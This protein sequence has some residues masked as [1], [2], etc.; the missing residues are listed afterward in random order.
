MPNSMEVRGQIITDAIQTQYNIVRETLGVDDFHSTATLWN[1]GSI[2]F[3]K[4]YLK[5]PQNTIIVFC[6]FGIDQMLGEDFYM[7]VLE[8]GRKCGI[9]Y[10]I[11]YF[12]RGPHLT[13]GCHPEKMAYNYRNAAEYGKL[14][15]SILNVSNVRPFHFSVTMN[16]KLMENPLEVNMAAKMLEFDRKVYG[17]AGEEVNALRKEYYE[18][19]ADFREEPLKGKMERWSFY[20]RPYEDISFMRNAATDGQLIWYGKDVLSGNIFSDRPDFKED[21]QEMKESARRFEMLY[22][23]MDLLEQKLPQ[24]SIPYF[25]KFLKH[26]TQHMQLITEWCVACTSLKDETL[27][28]EER[29]NAGEFACRCLEQLLQERKV[30][31]EGKWENWHRGEKKMNL[32]MR[33]EETRE[34]VLDLTHEGKI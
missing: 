12:A 15:Y 11:A 1:E 22:Q 24:E 10:H 28:S 14:D 23:K 18:C 5:L 8:D 29:K 13:E 3:G 19:F 20:Y 2:L 25:R 4:G 16:A 27:S 30:L 9:Y 17:D 34:R 21:I 7:P 32:T 33:L 26:Q 6:D 31:E